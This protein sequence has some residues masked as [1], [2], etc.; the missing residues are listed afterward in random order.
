MAMGRGSRAVG[1][2][3]SDLEHVERA[4]L[5]GDPRSGVRHLG[6][7]VLPG[8]LAG[9]AHHH[10]VAVRQLDRQRLAPSAGAQHEPARVARGRRSRPWCPGC[11][12]GRWCRRARRRCPGRRGSS[13][14][15]RSRTARPA[16]AGSARRARRAPPRAPGAAAPRRRRRCARAAGRRPGGRTSGGA[17]PARARRATSAANALVGVGQPRAVHV[18]PGAPGQR[19]PLEGVEGA[20]RRG[21]VGGRLEERSLEVHARSIPRESNRCSGCGVSRAVGHHG[22]QGR[23]RFP[24]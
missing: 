12:P 16:R 3:A 10:E 24:G 21:A 9:A 17:P 6:Y 7:G 14:S 5:H 20:P 15:P 1:S 19:A 23:R 18:D 4:V 22:M 2:P 8:P 11:D 13:S